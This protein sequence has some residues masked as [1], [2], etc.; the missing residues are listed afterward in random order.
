MTEVIVARSQNLY[1][2]AWHYNNC[3]PTPIVDLPSNSAVLDLLPPLKFKL[4]L[5]FSKSWTL[6]ICKVL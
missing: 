5:S 1:I 6:N 2:C 4:L 3:S